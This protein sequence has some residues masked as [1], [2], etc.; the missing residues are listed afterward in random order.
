MEISFQGDKF[1]NTK[2]QTHTDFYQK[3]TIVFLNHKYPFILKYWW[4]P[5]WTNGFYE[6]FVV[7]VK[8]A[9]L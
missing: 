6:L 4:P 3:L 1:R 2:S 8:Y 7:Y 9:R 5:P